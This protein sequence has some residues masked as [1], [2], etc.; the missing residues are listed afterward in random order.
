MR[1]LDKLTLG[2]LIF[3]LIIGLLLKLINT[4]NIANIYLA[5]IFIFVAL[6]IAFISVKKINKI[7]GLKK[8]K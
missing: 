1:K 5:F 4:I 7:L 6:G 3:V 2:F 8:E